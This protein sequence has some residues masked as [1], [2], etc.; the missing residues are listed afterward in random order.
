MRKYLLAKENRDTELLAANWQLTCQLEFLI[1]KFNR[2]FFGV[3]ANLWHKG[4]TERFEFSTEF[5]LINLSDL[6]IN[7]PKTTTTTQKTKTTTNEE[8]EDNKETNEMVR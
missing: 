6:V 2:F 5:S 4:H 3:F 7:P 8:E 1:Y